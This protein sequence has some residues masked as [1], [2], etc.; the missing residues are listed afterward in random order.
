MQFKKSP[1]R[2][3]APAGKVIADGQHVSACLLRNEIVVQPELKID[4]IGETDVLVVGGGPA[5]TAAAIAAA[6]T[7]VRVVLAERYGYLGGL[8]TGGLVLTI[9]G[10]WTDDPL[11]VCQG[12]G[13]EMM[14][15]LEEIP[16]GIIRRE[17]GINPV[18]D[19]ELFKLVLARM[20]REAGVKLYL[21][22]Y[23][24]SAILDGQ[25][26]VGAVFQTKRGPR[27][28]RAKQIID[29]TGDGD[30]FASAGAA[31]EERDYAVGL[32]YRFG[33]IPELEK[34]H[35]FVG[36]P[37]PLTG[38]HWA[39]SY[40]PPEG[41]G[42]GLDAEWMTHCEMAH[43]E[44]IWQ[45]LQKVRLVPG[46]ENASLVE[47]APQLGVRISR[48]LVGV[49]TITFDGFIRREHFDDCIGLG[50]ADSA[51]HHAWEI[52]LAALIPRGI[53]NLLTA[54]R[55][56]S[57]DTK[58]T[59]LV[60]LIPNCWVSGQGAGVAAAC[61]VMEARNVRSVDYEHVRRILLEQKVC[62]SCDSAQ[63][64]ME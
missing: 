19:G 47:V 38:V 53:E 29:T 17:K 31:H 60:R 51:D 34:R 39:S 49:K 23:A 52:P 44:Q 41:D 45:R 24:L 3:N 16:N 56:A 1:Y 5:G 57:F 48:V 54:G 6:R 32:A 14:Q 2:M 42:D 43:R 7:G 13:E 18:V 59:D 30:V 62:L 55:S 36:D 26:V 25:Q 9:L 21:H 40:A 64:S 28:I 50:G 15:R 20:I 4:T 58:M 33:G 63:A 37:T 8:A 22:N 35:A 11:Q 27:A 12:V 61:A 46:C 10:H